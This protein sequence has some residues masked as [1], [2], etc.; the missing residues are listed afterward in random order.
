MKNHIRGHTGEKPYK[1][2]V[3]DK[4]FRRKSYLT[5]HLKQVHSYLQMEFPPVPELVFSNEDKETNLVTLHDNKSILLVSDEDNNSNLVTLNP[6]NK[7][8]LVVP[9]EDGKTN[10]VVSNEDKETNSK[11]QFHS[12]KVKFEIS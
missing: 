6:D 3:C 9:S 4:L 2:P 5:G 8:N 11:S 10:L 1:C 12:A 7:S